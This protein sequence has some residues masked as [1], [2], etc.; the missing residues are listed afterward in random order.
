VIKDVRKL[1][2]AGVPLTVETGGESRLTDALVAFRNGGRA[3]L[4]EFMDT[5]KAAPPPP[6]IVMARKGS[7]AP[8]APPAPAAV[9]RESAPSI[10][11]WLALQV[12]REDLEKKLKLTAGLLAASE[13][14]AAQNANVAVRA[15]NE[16][17]A[18]GAELASKTQRLIGVESELSAAVREREDLKVRLG[19]ALARAERLE[20]DL[21]SAIKHA[22]AEN[23]RAAELTAG[24]DEARE[25]LKVETAANAKLKL[26]LESAQRS[27]RQE[28]DRVT[29]LQQALL[30]VREQAEVRRRQEAEAALQASTAL[31]RA[32][33]RSQALE[34]ELARL[35]SE[36]SAQRA[37]LESEAR[38]FE[39]SRQV[40]EEA[41]KDSQVE[42]RGTVSE[43]VRTAARR[44]RSEIDGASARGELSGGVASGLRELSKQLGLWLAVSGETVEGND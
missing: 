38:A 12:E 37:R 41:A 29:L 39:L 10:D 42:R 6:R 14:L 33:N 27:L 43:D 16:A 25:Q 22:R 2:E 26:D 23:G 44:L 32:E 15:G 34:S 11:H 3:G 21:L 35:R 8:K 19:Q 9:A 36:Y 30:T 13:R 17:A 18:A 24:L 28:L 31:R 4:A 40:F 5:P 20:A 7:D 1:T